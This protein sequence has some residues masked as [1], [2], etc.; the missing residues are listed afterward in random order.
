MKNI[1]D[2][3]I[4]VETAHLGS[5]SACARQMNLSAAVTSA[6]IKRLEDELDVA[7][8]VRSTRRLR[9]TEQ[10]EAFLGYC[11]E[12]LAL[13]DNGYAAMHSN[14]PDQ[15]DY[16]GNIRLSAPSDFGR[17]HLLSWLDAFMHQHPKVSIQLH[18][19]DSYADLYS[20]QIDMVLRYG[21]PK[22]TS[23]VALPLFTGNRAVV[24][25]SPDYLARFGTPL[26]PQALT[27][28][29]CLCLT[30]DGRLH[31][32]W[33]F[34]SA[35][36]S[37]SIEVK[38]NRSSQ[39]GEVVRRWAVAGEG[40]ALKSHLD[41]IADV[42]AGRLQVLSLDGWQGRTYPLYLV[43]AERRM[44]NPLYREVMD[45]LKIRLN[46]LVIIM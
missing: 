15:Q 45:Y 34:E 35:S 31:T 11:Q 5:L 1:Q 20:Q 6:S 44:I 24:C 8:F 21:H 30:Q 43:F 17:N 36:Q 19:S 37:M 40:V 7:L 33:Q 22:D 42:Q 28:H 14:K 27:Q 32:R 38:G 10:G 41:I 18:L 13:L 26:T 25:A 9:L 2:L 29:N 23:L 39:D 4:F 12:A 16:Q 3:R 46:E